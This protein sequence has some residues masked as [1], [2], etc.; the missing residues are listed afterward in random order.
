MTLQV[1]AGFSTE[2]MTPLRFIPPPA[3]GTLQPEDVAALLNEPA[4]WLYRTMQV[5]PFE[6][7]EQ[8][9]N[10]TVIGKTTA[11]FLV[12]LAVLAFR[13]KATAVLPVAAM[14]R[15]ILI[16]Y[17]PWQRRDPPVPLLNLL[18]LPARAVALHNEAV[19]LLLLNHDASAVRSAMSIVLQD[20]V[21]AGIHRAEA[22]YYVVKMLSLITGAYT[23]V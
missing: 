9:L 19:R 16:D 3:G 23:Q 15:V 7:P 17:T 10:A 8:S 14:Y 21:I 2:M 12:S 1:A 18:G 5:E 20:G 13:V 11:E 6:L 22:F 4:G